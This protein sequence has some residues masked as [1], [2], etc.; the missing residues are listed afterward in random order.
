MDRAA[1]ETLVASHR[2]FLAFVERRVSSRAVAE[3]ILQDAFVRGIERGGALREDESATAWFYRV[4]RNAI[5][6]H[7]RRRGTEARALEALARELDEEAPEAEALRATVCGCVSEIATT[8]KPEYA[9]ILRAVEVEGRSV[10]DFA[11]AHGIT[12]N[13]AA[14]RVHR[15]REALR[16]QVARACGTCATHGCFDCTCSKEA[17]G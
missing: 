4:L 13:N 9:E 12:P 15:A 16:T 8:L 3:E 14:V 7:H 1:L 10:K 2:Q 17:H 6:D 5:V 11:G